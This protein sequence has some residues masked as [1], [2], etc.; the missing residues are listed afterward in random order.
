M[1]PLKTFD[2]LGF[3]GCS[4]VQRHVMARNGEGEYE[5]LPL[6]LDVEI[7]IGKEILWLADYLLMHNLSKAFLDQVASC[8]DKSLSLMSPCGCQYT[9]V[10]SFL[11]AESQNILLFEGD[12]FSFFLVQ[13]VT[14]CDYW[15]IP[16]LD[17]LV[18]VTSPHVRE[19]D[20]KGKV[21]SEL[22]GR[23]R[24]IDE[25]CGDQKFAFTG[26]IAS[27]RRPAHFFYDCLIV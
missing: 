19:I 20:R 23:L 15:M 9:C 3:T 26:V 5:G 8:P 7:G 6:A 24:E 12:E 21:F 13:G 17:L 14:T 16:C 11:T 25:E 2:R 18:E 1:K 10:A 22:S 27:H 4:G